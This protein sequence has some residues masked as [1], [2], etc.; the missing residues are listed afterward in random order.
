MLRRA[1]AIVLLASVPFALGCETGDDDPDS[2]DHG[3]SEDDPS[4]P[5]AGHDHS[6]GPHDGHIMELGESYHIEWTH[7]DDTGTVTVYVLDSSMKKVVN[8]DSVKIRTK[9]KE[10]KTYDLE[11]VQ[12]DEESFFEL[13]DG[14]L[15]A[16]LDTVGEGVSA[17]VEV[18]VD[19]KTL[20]QEFEEHAEHSH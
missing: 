3:N 7:N 17:S 15:L 6:S 8:A 2:D 20:S 5:H 19:G 12:Q 13:K 11:L 10:S 16:I 1:F 18:V 14:S 9:V 4:D